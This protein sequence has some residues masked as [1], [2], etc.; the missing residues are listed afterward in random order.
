MI[1]RKR[2]EHWVLGTEDFNKLR[3]LFYKIPWEE[4]LIGKTAEELVVS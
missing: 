4:S 2:R 1:L 3:E